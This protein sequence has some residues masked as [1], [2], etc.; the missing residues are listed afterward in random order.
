MIGMC[1]LPLKS[2]LQADSLFLDRTLEVKDRSSRAAG[3][4]ISLTHD[5]DWPLVGHLK[6]WIW[7]YEI[8]MTLF[9]RNEIK[10]VS[11]KLLMFLC[12]IWIVF[13]IL[14]SN[15]SVRRSLAFWEMVQYGALQIFR[16]W[17]TCICPCPFC[18]VHLHSL[19][20]NSVVVI[21]MG[22]TASA[23]PDNLIFYNYQLELLHFVTCTG[24]SL[25]NTGSCWLADN[26]AVSG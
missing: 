21:K 23:K 3:H 12:C 22:R 18:N 11:C 14:R 19:I 16:Q 1:C 25:D 5:N 15:V 17:H 10:L 9:C 8:V 7:P 4:N 20:T 26:C 6:V 2:V 13:G 24:V